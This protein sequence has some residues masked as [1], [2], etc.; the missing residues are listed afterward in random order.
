MG[1]RKIINTLLIA[2]VLFATGCSKEHTPTGPEGPFGNTPVTIALAPG[3]RATVSGSHLDGTVSELRILLFDAKTGE[4]VLNRYIP[5]FSDTQPTNISVLT[6]KYHIVFIANESSEPAASGLTPAL[7]AMQKGMAVLS[8][9]RNIGFSADAFETD[10]NIP[11]TTLL[12]NVVIAGEN[13]VTLSGNSASE[14]MPWRIPLTRLATR[15]D[16]TFDLTMDEYHD[17]LAAGDPPV[18]TLSNIPSQVFLLEGS[19]NNTGFPLTKNIIFDPGNP[20]KNDGMSFIGNEPKVSLKFDRI[21]IPENMFSPGTDKDKGVEISVKLAGHT[22]HTFRG[23]VGIDAHGGPGDF[24]LPRNSYLDITASLNL[25]FLD[26][27]AEVI[28][29]T[30]VSTNVVADEQFYLKTNKTQVKFNRIYNN[31]VTIETDYDGST[32]YEAGSKID[33]EWQKPSWLTVT[34]GSQSVNNGIYT[35]TYTFSTIYTQP[36]ETTVHIRAGNLRYVLKVELESLTDVFAR[37]NIV[38]RGGRLV[39]ATT[40]EENIDIPAS[41]AGIFFKWGSL[42]GLGTPGTND[43]QLSHT[44]IVFKPAELTASAP[45][46]WAGIYYFNFLEE[47]SSNPFMTKYPDKGY[48]ATNGIGDICRYISDKKW[49]QGSWRMPTPGEIAA[50]LYEPN[51]FSAGNRVKTGSFGPESIAVSDGIQ[52]MSS[53]WWVG[54]NAL[55]SMANTQNMLIPP[56]GTTFI[57]ATGRTYLATGKLTNIGQEGAV[58]TSSLATDTSAG[59]YEFGSSSLGNTVSAGF[60]DTAMPIRCVRASITD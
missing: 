13:R 39:F 57:P 9:L 28:E 40:P 59:Y 2:V 22:N 24:T 53:G 44:N 51:P 29:W 55:P 38:L 1:I 36:A 19:N 10:K 20:N 27:D 42:F 37:S 52:P 15:L 47:N 48:D 41:S 45:S 18:L 30:D 31:T 16:I 32:G 49:V 43:T 46:S 60:R 3:T 35:R 12:E 23:I 17:L 50:L 58:W 6:G 7:D 5:A 56:A 21:I 26:M 4:L 8:D 54:I 14:Q 34:P 11:M 25:P 33:P